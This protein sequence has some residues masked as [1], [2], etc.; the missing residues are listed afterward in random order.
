MK[1]GLGIDT[2][3]TYTDAVIYDFDGGSALAW[4]KAP[5]TRENLA[6]GIA[7]AMDTLPGDLIRQVGRVA[8][9]TTLATNACVEGRGGRS[10]ERLWSAWALNTGCRRCRRSFS[11]TAAMTARGNQWQSLTG[12]R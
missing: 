3:G 7:A 8:L 2:G 5:T 10:S 4:G 6:D 11:S 1:L 12:R 9:S